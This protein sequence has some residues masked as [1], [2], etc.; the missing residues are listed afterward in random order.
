MVGGQI[1]GRAY[2]QE[3]DGVGPR[4]CVGKDLVMRQL[5]ETVIPVVS[6]VEGGCLL[7]GARMRQS[8]IDIIEWFNGEIRGHCL[9]VDWD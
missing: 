9:D 6:L 7:D 4:V 8:K 2:G 3:R 5:Y 1:G